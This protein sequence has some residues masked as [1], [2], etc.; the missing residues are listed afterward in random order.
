MTMQRGFFFTLDALFGLAL[1]LFLTLSALQ[2]LASVEAPRVPEDARAAFDF[3]N[4][5]DE[6]ATLRDAVVNCK[7]PGKPRDLLDAME[8]LP[9]QY[10]ADFRVNESSRKCL[11][12]AA[13]CACGSRPKTTVQRAFTV[14]SGSGADDVLV[15]LSLCARDVT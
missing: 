5:L 2:L 8:A 4:A 10:C 1:A 11:V 3:L 13:R 15:E 9:A 12:S 14:A 7:N 6:N